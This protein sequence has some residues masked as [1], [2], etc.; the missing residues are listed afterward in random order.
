MASIAMF[1][2]NIKVK[3]KGAADKSSAFAVRE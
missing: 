3:M 1:T 2:Q